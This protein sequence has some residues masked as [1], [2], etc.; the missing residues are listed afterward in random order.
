VHPQDKIFDKKR[1][2]PLRQDAIEFEKLSSYST[3]LTADEIPGSLEDHITIKWT[4]IRASR[5]DEG[6]KMSK[7]LLFLT[8]GL[9]RKE[10]DVV[11]K[12]VIIRRCA[13][14]ERLLRDYDG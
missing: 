8:V 4:F 12:L 1:D 5:S 2:V 14:L 3:R 13:C 10:R 6:S 11:M 9:V 7:R